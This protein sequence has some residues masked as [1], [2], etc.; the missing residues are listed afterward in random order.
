[1]VIDLVCKM[2]IDEEAASYSLNYEGRDYF[3]CSE[4]CMEEFTRRPLEYVK[5]DSPLPT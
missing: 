1:M 4:G 3:F 2:K 5:S